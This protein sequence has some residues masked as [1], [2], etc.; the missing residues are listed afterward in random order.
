MCRFLKKYVRNINKYTYVYL[1]TQTFY[2]AGLQRCVG[3]IWP[4][5]VGITIKA[6]CCGQIVS[7]YK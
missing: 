4:S 3:Y 2:E 1:F 7:K 5:V 6:F